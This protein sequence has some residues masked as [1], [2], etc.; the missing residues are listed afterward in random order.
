MKNTT[1]SFEGLKG[2][3]LN[4]AIE[5]HS[6][7]RLLKATKLDGVVIPAGAV[8]RV[9]H[10]SVSISQRLKSFKVVFERS[11][12]LDL[13][14]A[15]AHQTLPKSFDLNI[16]NSD[17]SSKEF[18]L[19]SETSI[20]TKRIQWLV[21]QPKAKDQLQ[22]SFTKDTRD[23]KIMMK[24]MEASEAARE[25]MRPAGRKTVD[26]LAEAIKAV[27]G[28]EVYVHRVENWGYPKS[29]YSW[30]VTLVIM[31]ASF[32]VTLGEKRPEAFL[33][34][35]TDLIRDLNKSVMG[36]HK[37]MAS[38]YLSGEST[39]KKAWERPDLVKPE[40][41]FEI[42]NSLLRLDH[43]GET[44][45]HAYEP[46][47]VDPDLLLAQV[48]EVREVLA[49]SRKVLEAWHQA[50]LARLDAAEEVLGVLAEKAEHTR[51]S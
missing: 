46:I 47:V 38:V 7:F 32:P 9:T 12:N 30:C 36:Q 49:K 21:R 25:Y 45:I 33:A 18:W 50:A 17:Y 6:T 28:I 11:Q 34:G 26:G 2:N 31:H 10:V 40:V 51:N 35:I 4:D 16:M 27:S 3:D 8:G 23:A 19:D 14:A 43:K 48:P 15:S 24:L 39:A 1:N 44:K 5:I 22:V 29:T 41:P 20:E 37:G 42:L 13:I